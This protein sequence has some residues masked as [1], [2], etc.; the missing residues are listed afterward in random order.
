MAVEARSATG[1]PDC[2]GEAAG[3]S[4]IYPEE[5]WSVS[6]GWS[7]GLGHR[8]LHGEDFCKAG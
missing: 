5:H 7:G 4:K 3:V 1:S 8:R 2:P 6:G